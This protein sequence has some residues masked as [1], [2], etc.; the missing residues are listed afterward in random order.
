M[1]ASYD[2]DDQMLHSE[3]L[4]VDFHHFAASYLYDGR[5]MAACI[6]MLTGLCTLYWNTIISNRVI[7]GSSMKSD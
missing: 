1:K 4:L 3:Q 2:C 6:S 7:G 5:D